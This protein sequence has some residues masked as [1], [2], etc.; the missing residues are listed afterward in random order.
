MH[1]ITTTAQTQGTNIHIFAC[2]YVM[3]CDL[4]AAATRYQTL[5]LNHYAF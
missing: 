2:F 3:S 1:L 4:G 5:F